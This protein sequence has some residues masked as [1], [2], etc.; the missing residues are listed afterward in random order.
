[1]RQYTTPSYTLTINGVD[2]TGC[3]VYV[4]FRQG[5]KTV[6]IDDP[7]VTHHAATETEPEKTVIGVSLTQEQTA[8]FNSRQDAD[9]QVNWI[10]VHEKR[11]ATNIKAVPVLPNLL[12]EI[13][14]YGV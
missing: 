6:T 8:A 7:T 10:D 2:L 5:V 9:V 14:E 3:D 4:T 13:L 1:M 12:P 11:N